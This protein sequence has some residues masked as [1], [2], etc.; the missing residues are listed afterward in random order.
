MGGNVRELVF[1]GLSL[2]WG[3]K[4]SVFIIFCQV[5]GRFVHVR[6][7]ERDISGFVRREKGLLRG[8]GDIL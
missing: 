5:G 1:V 4:D 7:Y 6:M 3:G 2:F 8:L